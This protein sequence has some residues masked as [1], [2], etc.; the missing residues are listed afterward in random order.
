MED[1][2]IK[3]KY[4]Y[5]DDT[6]KTEDFSTF[7]NITD[8]FRFIN[9][10]LE[11][12]YGDLVAFSKYRDTQTYIIGKEGKLIKNPDYSCAGYLTIPYEITN[13]L[14]NALEKYSEIEIQY[15]DLR[16]DDTFIKE[17]LNT[18]SCKILEKWNWKFSYNYETQE[19]DITFP[20]NTN[21]IYDV[22]KTSANKILKW[23][24]GSKL[25]QTEIEVNFKLKKNSSYNKKIPKLPP[26][27]DIEIS[28]SYNK[29]YR[30][31][32]FSVKGPTIDKDKVIN[33]I[34]RKFKNL[35]F[36]LNEL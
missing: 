14:D 32:T 33:S 30:P 5:Y 4:I 1:S 2:T 25:D 15:I 29:E 28:S 12:N 36:E 27:W 3:A 8:L 26:T 35:E 23:Y 31:V 24:N 19:L 18:K 20:N 7:R 10:D 16:F 22:K 21:N 11:Y 17:N 6:I 34:N 9:K 13:C